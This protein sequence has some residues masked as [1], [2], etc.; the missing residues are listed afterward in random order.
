[1]FYRGRTALNRGL[2]WV[3]IC[4]A[5]LPCAQAA[6]TDNDTVSAS[7]EPLQA[8]ALTSRWSRLFSGNKNKF[9]GALSFSS[10]MKQQWLTIPN[11]SASAQQKKKINQLL[12]LSLQYSPY[13]Y[14]FGNVILRAPI[15]DFDK[16]TTDFRYSF[17][18][19][20]W[21]PNTF[22]LVYSNYGDNHL[23]TSGNARHTYF[24]QGA[25]T[26]AYKFSLPKSLEKHLLINKGDALTCQVGYSW[27]PRY[28]SLAD[29]DIRAN[30]QVGLGGCGYTFKQHF[31]IRATAFWYPKSEQQQPWNG[32][33]SYSF[34]YAGYTPGSFS[35]QYS[36]Y[37]GTHFPG[38]SNS[39]AKFREGTVSLIWFLP[40]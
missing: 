25:F 19:D 35:V 5:F 13:S 14:W 27:V 7:S 21:H 31:F 40:F 17:G 6:T 24:E 15:T 12:N 10:G 39:N 8:A 32:D 23:F 20:D 37:S 9:S 16:Y 34:G 11:G 4:A 3:L 2:L 29:N 33:Y 1:M 28:Y 18:Y 30:K 26:F 22:S 38:R 36:N